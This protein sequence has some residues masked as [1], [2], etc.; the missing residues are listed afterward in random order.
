MTAL[1]AGALESSSFAAQ[2]LV[3]L[4]IYEE[5]LVKWNK[6]INLVAPSSLAE[7]GE[8]HFLD[9]LQLLDLAPET[10]ETWADLGSGGGF[11]GLVVSIL[12]ASKRPNL[13]LVLV[14]ADQRKAEFLRTVSRETGVTVEVCAERIEDCLPLDADVIS[15]RALAPLSR[16]C[17]YAARHLATDGTCLF[18]KGARHEAEIADAKRTWSF[19]ATA[20]PSRTKRDSSILVVRNLRRG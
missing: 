6:A 11:P 20:L 18:M 9:S 3:R 15:A 14:E 17:D 12:A 1:P 2:V 16:L 10:A 5:L 13:R 19:D 8:R 7:I 4:K